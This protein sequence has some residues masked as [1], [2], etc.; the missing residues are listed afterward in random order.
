MV[1]NLYPPARL[2]RKTSL[3]EDHFSDEAIIRHDVEY[4][5]EHTLLTCRNVLRGR[6]VG[7]RTPERSR[8][9]HF[10]PFRHMPRTYLSVSDERL[11]VLSDP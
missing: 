3:C 10:P 5:R 1:E 6:A 4:I 2:L 11:P 7:I 9:L 8:E